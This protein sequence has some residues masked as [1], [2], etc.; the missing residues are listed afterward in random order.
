MTVVTSPSIAE[1]LWF[2]EQH[3]TG[4]A[5]TGYITGLIRLYE[6]ELTPD[7]IREGPGKIVELGTWTGNSAF[8]WLSCLH[9]SHSLH[10]KDDRLWT[11]DT[12]QDNS[13]PLVEDAK[14]YGWT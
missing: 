7:I 2:R 14:R 1:R 6:D 3:E 10:N 5:G 13:G 12:N 9:S 4:S 11:I 8:A